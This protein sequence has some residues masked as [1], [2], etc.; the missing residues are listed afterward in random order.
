MIC[1][2]QSLTL[3]MLA[4]I[5]GAQVAVLETS[6]L[7]DGRGGT[8]KDKRIVIRDGKIESIGSAK[9][10]PGATVWGRPGPPSPRPRESRSSACRVRV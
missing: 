2:I 9:I 7:L 8:L 1:S 4:P 6:T 3:L 5:L 10:P